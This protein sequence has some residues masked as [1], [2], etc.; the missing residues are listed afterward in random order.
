MIYGVKQYKFDPRTGNHYD[1]HEY[2]INTLSV[3]FMINPS[4][5][6]E[7]DWRVLSRDKDDHEIVMVRPV[8]ELDAEFMVCTLK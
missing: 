2:D 3:E 5:I 4:P 8:G 1:E 7:S 6:E